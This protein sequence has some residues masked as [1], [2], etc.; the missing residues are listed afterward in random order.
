VPPPP[1]V[2]SELAG[3]MLMWARV[4]DYNQ[5]EQEASDDYQCRMLLQG[6][7]CRYVG[8]GKVID[9]VAVFGT[10][11]MAV[12]LLLYIALQGMQLRD[13][14]QLTDNRVPSCGR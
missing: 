4:W 11:A 8:L 13:A 10:G 9:V 6:T 7:S 14:A 12:F 3:D 2:C 1:V 5:R